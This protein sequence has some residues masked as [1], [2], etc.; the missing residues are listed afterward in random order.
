MMS[1]TLLT[2]TLL[3]L[4]VLVALVWARRRRVGV[5]GRDL[6]KRLHEVATAQTGAKAAGAA[7][8]VRIQEGRL[9]AVDQLV[10]RTK[11]G[12]SLARLIEQSGVP[13]TTGFI[14]VASVGGALACAL[15]TAVLVRQWFVIP[16]V[17]ILAGMAPYWFLVHKRTKRM[18]RFEEQFPESLELLSRA[19]RAGHAFQTA[20]SMAGDELPTPAGPEFKKTFEEQ[21]FGLPLKEALTGL[22]E[23]VPLLD[24]RF[25]VTAVLIQRETGGNLAEILD[26]LAHVV[27]ERFKLLRQVRIHTAHGRFTA[28]VLLCVPFVLGIFLSMINP[29]LMGLLFRDR[30]GHMLLI[31]GLGLQ[32]IGYFWIR[33]VIRIEV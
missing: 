4:V 5:A 12:V 22:S 13:T 2:V 19:I 16:I 9:L 31:V 26:N 1:R 8:V 30:M 25:F 17:A 24:V 14:V 23:R 10:S 21:N 29:D 7:P 28:Y 33:Q 18:K 27:R 11:T 20:M 3:A 15:L 32:V 6:I